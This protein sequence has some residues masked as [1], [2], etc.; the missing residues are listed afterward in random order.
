MHIAQVTEDISEECRLCSLTTSGVM[1]RPCVL[2]KGK[3]SP[4]FTAL[5]QL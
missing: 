3:H 5:N 1:K 4:E 2:R